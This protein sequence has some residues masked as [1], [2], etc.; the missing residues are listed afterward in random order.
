MQKVI[1]L[2]RKDIR[3]WIILAATVLLFTAI[4]RADRAT[5]IARLVSA[6][7]A[8]KGTPTEALLAAFAFI[9]FLTLTINCIRD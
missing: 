3:A 1:N 7:A 6:D 9:A 4:A 8:Q 2:F 5:E